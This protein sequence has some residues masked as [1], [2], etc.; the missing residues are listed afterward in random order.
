MVNIFFIIL[1]SEFQ[2]IVCEINVAVL[3]VRLICSAPWLTATLSEAEKV[4]VSLQ[5]LREA[6]ACTEFTEASPCAMLLMNS[7]SKEIVIF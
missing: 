6:V 4:S 2:I 1:K 7:A 3:E 5:I